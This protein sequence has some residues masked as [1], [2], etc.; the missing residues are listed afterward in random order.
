MPIHLDSGF[1]MLDFRKQSLIYHLSSKIRRSR[2]RGFT[3]IELLVVITIIALLI[4]AATVSYTKVQQKGRD[5]KR[6][7]DL[8][9]IQQALEI[10]YQTYGTY[11]ISDIDSLGIGMICSGAGAPGTVLWGSVFQCPPSTGPIFMQKLP[12]DPLNSG[13][14]V[15]FYTGG[16]PIYTSTNTYILSAQLENTGDPE[17]STGCNMGN[18]NYCVTNP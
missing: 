2:R 12:K 5:T 6:K 18:H 16:F 9:A 4:G 17:I 8:K 1:W 14:S 11:T 15:Y 7:S 13:L 3:L 10:Y